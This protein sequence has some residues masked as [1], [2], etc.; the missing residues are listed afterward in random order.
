MKDYNPMARVLNSIKTKT[1][2]EQLSRNYNHIIKQHA[3]ITYELKDVMS[4][5][6]STKIVNLG[7]YICVL[8]FSFFLSLS[9]SL[10]KCDKIFCFFGGSAYVG[11]G[12]LYDATQR[13]YGVTPNI[14][15]ATLEGFLKVD[16]SIFDNFEN[17]D[18]RNLAKQ[19]YT[20]EGKF[21]FLSQRI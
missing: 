13:V 1:Q 17:F 8:Y 16:S 4:N 18:Y 12:H 7:M 19:L 15:H 5:V 3:W 11:L 9:L 21:Y 10:S 14:F 2:F 6:Q 20:A